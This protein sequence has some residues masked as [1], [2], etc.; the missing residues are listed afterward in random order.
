MLCPLCW[1]EPRRWAFNPAWGKASWRRYPLSCLQSGSYPGEERGKKFL[2][3]LQWFLMIAWKI[4]WATCFFKKVQIPKLCLQKFCSVVCAEDLEGLQF[5][6]YPRWHTAGGLRATLGN[7]L[8]R[9]KSELVVASFSLVRLSSVS[10]LTWAQFCLGVHICFS[11][12]A[13]L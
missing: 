1:G 13:F 8:G 4:T 2:D 5:T 9:R 10:S 3:K 6:Y 7:L 12:I 11:N